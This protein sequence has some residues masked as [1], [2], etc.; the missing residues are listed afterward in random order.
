M[1]TIF[2]KLLLNTG[3]TVAAEVDIPARICRMEDAVAQYEAIRKYANSEYDFGD[4]YVAEV[5]DVRDY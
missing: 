5:L 4:G 2:V 1:R 3:K